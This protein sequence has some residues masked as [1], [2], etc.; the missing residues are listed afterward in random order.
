VAYQWKEGAAVLGTES[1]L[2]YTANVGVHTVTLTVTDNGGATATDDVVI[3]VKQA[4]TMH[5][6]SIQMS[7]VQNYFGLITYA[8]ATVK[9]V[10]SNGNVVQG[11][12]VTGHWEIATTDHESGTANSSGL[13]TFQ[14]DS[15]RQ[16]AKG[17]RFVFV[18][19][20]VTKDGW[21]WDS[22]GSVISGQIAVP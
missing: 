14:S 21:G 7:L 1:T 10:D 9:V 11:A 8:N 18:V 19:D 4:L 20:S 15:L 17:T 3:V 12:V 5:V 22:Q 16:P 6:A 2:T 13:V